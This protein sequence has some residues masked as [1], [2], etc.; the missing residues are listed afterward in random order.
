MGGDQGS[1]I[2]VHILGDVH[3][4]RRFHVAIDLPP[5]EGMSWETE[6][7]FLKADLP[8]SFPA[9]LGGRG[10]LDRWV[11]SF[12]MYDNY[13]VIEERDGFVGRLPVDFVQPDLPDDPDWVRPTKF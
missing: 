6:V 5:F 1:D 9:I 10:F 11:A 2:W 7:A 8:L 13:F 12:N 3:S 4:A